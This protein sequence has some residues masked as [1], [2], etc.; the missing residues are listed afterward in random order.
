MFHSAGR[1][2]RRRQRSG[3]QLDSRKLSDRDPDHKIVVRAR[4]KCGL[5]KLEGHNQAKLENNLK[6]RMCIPPW[7]Y[8]SSPR[9]ETVWVD[10][11]GPG[12]AA[13]WAWT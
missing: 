8:N 5:I 13:D 7:T 11:M 2:R 1:P 6:S 3:I 10:W 9:M 4:K 12:A